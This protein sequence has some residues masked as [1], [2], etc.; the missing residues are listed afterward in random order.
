VRASP[1]PWQRYQTTP[2][3]AKELE[4]LWARNPHANVGM[5]LGP[6]SG[7][8]GSDIDGTEGVC[9]LEQ[10]I[11][12]IPETLAFTTP[13]GQDRRRLLFLH[14]SI[15]VANRSLRVDGHEAVRIMTKGTQTVMPPSRHASGGR[16][17]VERRLVG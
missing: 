12:I 8:I 6:I 13:G 17:P 11:G 9:R 2:P 10:I 4:L 5:A 15:E 1:W 7:L 16:Y 3:T 14:P